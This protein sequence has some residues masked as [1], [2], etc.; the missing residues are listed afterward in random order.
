M[1]NTKYW[2]SWIY[3]NNISPY[4]DDFLNSCNVNDT[5]V[6]F[7][8]EEREITGNYN[9]KTLKK[10]NDIS[11]VLGTYDSKHLK[12]PKNVKVYYFENFFAYLALKMPVQDINTNVDKKFLFTCMIN[13]PCHTR[14][15]LLDTLAKQNLLT[16]NIY[17]WNNPYTMYD[18]YTP[19][20]WKPE[21]KRIKD[22][23]NDYTHTY[24]LSIAKSVIHL[25]PESTIDVSFVTE[26]TYRSI[27]YK[28]PFIIY[29]KPR[30]HEYLESI[31][32]KLPRHIIQYDKFDNIS[33]TF[34]KAEAISNELKR[35]SEMNLDKL[36]A[37]LRPTSE[38]NYYHLL[39]MIQNTNNIPSIVK[40]H[41]VYKSIIK[42]AIKKAKE[43]YLK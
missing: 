42:E 5:I 9:Y 19:K 35:L 10:F 24:P 39:K 11:M 1:H 28:M 6:L 20:Y 26:K 40:N 12:I 27:L 37:Q 8:P 3:E 17:S 36:A 18:C 14:A 16:N 13:R 2:F 4:I 32:F 25:V 23:A 22:D 31:G 43:L 29:G 41:K 21:I 38:Y 34:E 7:L 33:N 30:F 15:I